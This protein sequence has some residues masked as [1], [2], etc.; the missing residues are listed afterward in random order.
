M[1]IELYFYN[2]I[3]KLSPYDKISVFTHYIEQT[4]F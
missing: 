1:E 4:Y 2:T 3:Q